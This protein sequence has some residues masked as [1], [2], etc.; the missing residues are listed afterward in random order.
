M[1]LQRG[2]EKRNQNSHFSMATTT[3]AGHCNSLFPNCSRN[4]VQLHETDQLS[5]VV[6]VEC[7]T[8][9]S[10]ELARSMLAR[11]AKSYK[12]AIPLRE[13]SLESENSSYLNKSQSVGVYV[14]LLRCIS[15]SN[16]QAKFYYSQRS[17]FFEDGRWIKA[18]RHGD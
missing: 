13:N 14:T 10:R 15:K 8:R 18:S 3:W 16:Q 7:Q 2:R 17:F 5:T 11:V 12:L 6:L 4:F 9:N 1:I